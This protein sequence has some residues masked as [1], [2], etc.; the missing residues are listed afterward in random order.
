MYAGLLFW[1]ETHRAWIMGAIG[2]CLW[3][4]AN[5]V[6]LRH[7]I[8][9]YFKRRRAARWSVDMATRTITAGRKPIE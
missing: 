8:R 5:Y 4:A 2:A 9:A 1:E 6:Y 3:I 7:D